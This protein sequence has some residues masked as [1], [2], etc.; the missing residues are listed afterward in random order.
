MLRYRNGDRVDCHNDDITYANQIINRLKSTD[1]TIACI[2]VIDT[3]SD[4]DMMWAFKVYASNAESIRRE[5]TAKLNEL[6][7][8]I[9]TLYEQN[10]D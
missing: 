5:L 1:S 7:A 4:D 6:G 8:L 10:K 3:I 9:N 2:K